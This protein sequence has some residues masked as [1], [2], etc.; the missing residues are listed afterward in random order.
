MQTKE[1]VYSLYPCFLVFF[2]FFF[3]HKYIIHEFCAGVAT[4]TDLISHQK[5]STGLI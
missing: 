5:D 4:S 2:S 1:Q 3:F